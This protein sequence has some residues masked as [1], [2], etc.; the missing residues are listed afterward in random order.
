MSVIVLYP[1]KT[2]IYAQAYMSTPHGLFRKGQVRQ[3]AASAPEEDW[4]NTL[5]KVIMLYSCEPSTEV[6]VDERLLD[7]TKSLIAGWTSIKIHD[8]E[9]LV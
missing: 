7:D 4:K 5:T 8:T 2:C 3:Y 6:V 9:T 1:R